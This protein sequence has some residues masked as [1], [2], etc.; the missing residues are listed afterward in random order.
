MHALPAAILATALFAMGAHAQTFNDLQGTPEHPFDSAA[1]A[2]VFVFVR[3]DCPIS[4]RYAPELQRIVSEFKGR[5]ADFWLVYSDHSESLANIQQQIA[6]YKLPGTALL[7]PKQE[8]AHRAQ[9]AVTPQAAVFDH[10]GRLQ[11]SGRIDDR[12]VDFGKSRQ[13]AATHDLEDAITATLAGKP[14]AQPRTRAIGCYLADI[15]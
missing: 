13:A 6:D 11:Y 5:A 7:D 4:N 8:L 10:D 15:K 12:Y 3:T 9:A 14:V 2:R 1:R